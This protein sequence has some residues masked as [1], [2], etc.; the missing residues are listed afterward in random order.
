LKVKAEGKVVPV[1]FLT[2][3]HAKKSYCG[4]ECIAP[5]IP[6]RGHYME[7]SGELHSPAALNPG[8]EPLVPIG[9]EARDYFF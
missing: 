9:Y 4:S 3:H 6:C 7:V 5:P 2:E 1:L 8:K